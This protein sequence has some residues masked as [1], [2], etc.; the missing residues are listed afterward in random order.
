[1]MSWLEKNSTALIAIATTALGA[2]YAAIRI[3]WAHLAE[4]PQK[5]IAELEAELK[6][7]RKDHWKTAMALERLSGKYE[8]R[9]AV[10]SRPPPSY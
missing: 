8:T 1:M 4:K 9:G 10:S 5:R 2:L 6:E 7:E 3:L